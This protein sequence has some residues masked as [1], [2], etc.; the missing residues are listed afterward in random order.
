MATKHRTDDEMT[1]CWNYRNYSHSFLSELLPANIPTITR[2]N[3][4]REL[5]LKC[6]EVKG[7]SGGSDNRKK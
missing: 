1:S 5:R 4:E 7:E 3:G 2:Q 6:R